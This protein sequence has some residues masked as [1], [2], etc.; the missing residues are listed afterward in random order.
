MARGWGGMRGAGV[1]VWGGGMWCRCVCVVGGGGG[2]W[3]EDGVARLVQVYVCGA[4][5]TEDRRAHV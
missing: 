4:G 5:G 3:S 2:M 1:C